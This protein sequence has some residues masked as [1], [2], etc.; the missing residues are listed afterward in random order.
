MNKKNILVVANQQHEENSLKQW[1][2]IAHP[3]HVNLVDNEEAAIEWCHLQPFDVVVVD[4]TDADIDMKKLNAVLPILQE[5][6]TLLKYEGE[7]AEEI[8]ENIEAVFNAKK[9]QRLQ[10][11]MMLEPSVTTTLNLPPFSL[12]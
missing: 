5:D 6:A 1:T 3:F 7:S 12:N 11:M 8:A 9:Y 4:G 2:S 10:R